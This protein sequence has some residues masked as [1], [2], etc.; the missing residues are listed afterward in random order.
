MNRTFLLG[1]FCFISI[2]IFTSPTNTQNVPSF[3]L[4]GHLEI[5]DCDTVHSSEYRCGE[6]LRLI[7]KI[8]KPGKPLTLIEHGYVSMNNER[9]PEVR[10]GVYEKY[11]DQD[12]SIW[13]QLNIKISCIPKKPQLGLS[14]ASARVEN[15]I[16][17]IVPE[18]D[19][20][21]NINTNRPLIFKWEFSKSLKKSRIRIKNWGTKETVFDH[22]YLRDSIKVSPNIFK[23]NTL[24]RIYQMTYDYDNFRLYRNAA[25]G[26]NM[27]IY[28]IYI[29]F[30][31]T[32]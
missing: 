17:F 14:I 19:G 1:I 11:F 30:F 28:Y 10:P 29:T 9:I 21:I 2:L 16:K 23:P 12:I 13:K 8:R 6:F 32:E 26:S 27:P 31:R 22:T 4:D 24:Y 25:P 3:Y 15:V 20:T 18:P 7:L 5:F